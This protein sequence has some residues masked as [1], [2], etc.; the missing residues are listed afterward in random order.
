[1]RIKIT[2]AIIAIIPLQFYE[3]KRYLDENYHQ[4]IA[5][6]EL[7]FLF[8]T[9]KTSL[10]MHFKQAFNKT[11]IG[12]LNALRIK[13]T[14]V[15]LRDGKY[16]LTQIAN[17]MHMS[18]VHYLTALFKKHTGMSPTE[19]VRSLQDNSSNSTIFSS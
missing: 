10:S 1:M 19:Y 11:I 7:C 14:K 16:T 13:S 18:S 12:Y 6:E 8:N 9:N 2:V 4:K 3:A 17:L 5:L 15:L